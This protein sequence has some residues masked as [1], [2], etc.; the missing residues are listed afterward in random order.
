[1]MTDDGAQVI[2]DVE[3]LRLAIATR[4]SSPMAKSHKRHCNRSAGLLPITRFL[5]AIRLLARLGDHHP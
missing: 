1:M 2:D 5:E 3:V 4:V